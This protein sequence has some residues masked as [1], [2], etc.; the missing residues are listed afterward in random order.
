MIAT[1]EVLGSNPGK[2]DNSLIPDL[3][4]NLKPKP[5]QGTPARSGARGGSG[6]LTRTRTLTRKRTRPVDNEVGTESKLAKWGDE[7]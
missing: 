3:E 5:A 7:M 4:G 1:G 6:P 2:G